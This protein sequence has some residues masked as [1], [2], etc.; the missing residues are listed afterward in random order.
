MAKDVYAFSY[1]L[2]QEIYHKALI[3]A[4]IVA[5]CFLGIFLFRT[6]ICYPVHSATQAMAP[7]IPVN[8]TTLVTPLFT[9]PHRGDVV[10][11][12]GRKEVK[13]HAVKRF[14]N[15]ICR[16]ISAQQWAPFTS[17]VPTAAQMQL[18][19]VTGLPGDTIYLN[20]YVLYVKPKGESHFL[21]EFEI[22][23]SKYTANIG[24]VP[25]QWDGELGLKSKMELVELGADEYF[26]LSDNR[27]E[28]ADSRLWG[29]VHK[30]DISA[31]A[32]ILYFPLHKIR[33]F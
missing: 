27:L 4:G 8:S 25:L 21:T 24:A 31:K 16:F 28:G 26:V 10:L 3:I 12:R 6:F 18:R 22:T 15:F 11:L 2:R 1:K 9:T 20:N 30:A 33:L 23:E 29:V 17:N 14:V 7:D 32:L 13:Q 5:L 19:R